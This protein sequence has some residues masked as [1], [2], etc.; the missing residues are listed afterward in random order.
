[1][2]GKTLYLVY[3]MEKQKLDILSGMAPARKKPELKK[4]LHQK[5]SENQKL[6]ITSRKSATCE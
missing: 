2:K 6:T 3:Q 4:R 5:L 1:M